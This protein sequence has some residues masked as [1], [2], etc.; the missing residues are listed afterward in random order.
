MLESAAEK[1]ED[2]GFL[3]EAASA[4]IGGEVK[5]PGDSMHTDHE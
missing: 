3:G 2:K 1:R 4:V 5:K